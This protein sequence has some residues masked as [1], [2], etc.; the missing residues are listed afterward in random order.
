MDVV[1]DADGTPNEK[2]VHQGD[3]TSSRLIPF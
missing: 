2:V 1:N 3:P